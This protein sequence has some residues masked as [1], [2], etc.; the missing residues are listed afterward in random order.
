MARFE[1]AYFLVI[2]LALLLR[3]Y[4]ADAGKLKCIKSYIHILI[5]ILDLSTSW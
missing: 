1:F 4:D 5:L 3:V 2:T